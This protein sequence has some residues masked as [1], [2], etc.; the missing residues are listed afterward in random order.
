MSTQITV[1]Y[2][3]IQIG[4][5]TAHIPFYGLT[6][7]LVHM[8]NIKPYMYM[9]AA[10]QDARRQDGGTRPRGRARVRRVGAPGRGVRH[11][12]IAAEA[13]AAYGP[14][15][16]PA[17]LPFPFPLPAPVFLPFFPLP[18]ITGDAL[19]HKAWMSGSDTGQPSC[20]VSPWSRGDQ[21]RSN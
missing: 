20:T 15:G 11:S 12:R 17:P 8:Y 18:P 13:V 9:H 14:R 2:A 1:D 5:H 19:S 3:V 10:P 16:L 21:L 7:R 4:E 6:V